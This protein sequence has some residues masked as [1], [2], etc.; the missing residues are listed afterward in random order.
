MT[1]G[2]VIMRL[3]DSKNNSPIPYRDSKLTRLLQPAL[4]GDSK[5]NIICNISPCEISYEEALSTL[6]FAQRAKKIKQTIGKNQAIDSKAL[7]VQYQR[8]IENLQ[9]R[10]HDMEEK[11]THEVDK[12]VPPEMTHQLTLLQEE[13]EKADERLEDLLQEKLQLQKELERYRS[14]IIHPEDI[15]THKISGNEFEDVD[16]K[17]YRMSI[18]I[19]QRIKDEVRPVSG[20]FSNIVNRK[21]SMEFSYFK[22]KESLLTEN[23]EKIPGILNNE[24]QMVKYLS[25][26]EAKDPHEDCFRIIDE[27]DK[28]IETL[29]KAL[30]EKNDE[31]EVLKDELTLC[32]NNLATLQRN[33]K[34]LNK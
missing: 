14:F 24:E 5:I 33:F 19:V 34:R 15:K 16:L 10:L 18:E 3:S 28:I 21:D 8:E 27:Q 20:N 22:P 9:I 30:S 1:L 23:I 29:Q 4:E 32:R 25:G 26:T 31:V 12:D 11:M 7:I 2:T 13:K 17:S 6:K